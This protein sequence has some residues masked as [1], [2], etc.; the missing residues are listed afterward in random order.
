L[1]DAKAWFQDALIKCPKGSELKLVF[2]HLPLSPF[3]YELQD[4]SLRLDSTTASPFFWFNY[5]KTLDETLA[6]AEYHIIIYEYEMA[7]EAEKAG[8]KNQYLWSYSAY[9]GSF[10]LDVFEN[11]K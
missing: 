8:R 11:K 6:A 9:I 1:E 2:L 10:G 3:M 7:L 4:P 5:A